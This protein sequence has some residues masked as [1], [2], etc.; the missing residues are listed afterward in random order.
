MLEEK[1]QQQLRDLEEAMKSTWE[2]KARISQAHE[3]DRK[4]LLKEQAEAENKLSI[5]Q[6][7]NW[8]LLEEKGD[9]GLSIGRVGELF[10]GITQSVTEPDVTIAW[11]SDLRDILK[12]EDR[13]SQ[14]DTVVEVYK[15]ALHA[16][17]SRFILHSNHEVGLILLLL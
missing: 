2:E 1:H 17:G 8:K 16:D 7:N 15:A 5:H 6:E 12:L 4:L 10:G 13:L 14:Q 9:L 3:N 11:S